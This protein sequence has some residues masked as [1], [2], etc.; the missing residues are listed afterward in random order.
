[1]GAMT[2]VIG[3]AGHPTGAVI[4]GD[5]RVTFS[6]GR[7]EVSIQARMSVL[8]WRTEYQDKQI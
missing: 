2:W 7:T 8:S 3:M 4:V 5:A 6:G 1:M